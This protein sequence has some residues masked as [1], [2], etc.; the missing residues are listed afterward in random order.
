[1]ERQVW[2]EIQDRVEVLGSK[3]IQDH[4]ELPDTPEPKVQLVALVRL[5]SPVSRALQDS[6]VQ[7][8]LQDQQDSR[9]IRER[10]V[11]QVSKDNREPLVLRVSVV[12]LEVL[13]LPDTQ[14]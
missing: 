3:A 4:R 9:A 2:L 13:D 7:L 10:M 8:D 6:T 1:M 14:D 12:K 5:V 11:N